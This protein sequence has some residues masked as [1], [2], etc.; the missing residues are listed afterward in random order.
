MTSNPQLQKL[1]G[2]KL[3]SKILNILQD[4]DWY[5]S[6]LELITIQKASI[7]SALF[8]CVYNPNSLI[9]W[10]AV[11]TFGILV[12]ILSINEIEKIRILVRRCIWMLT[13]ESGGIPWGVPE[14]IGEIC[15][16]SEQMAQEFNN[17]LLSYVFESNGPENYL[18]HT[19][20]RK[21]VYWGILRLAQSFPEKVR[22]FE[23]VIEQRIK[24]E[25]EPVI[26][27]Y[28][29]MIIDQANL[30]ELN[31]YCNQFIKDKRKIEIFINNH[32]INTNLSSIA[33][34]IIIK[35]ST[36]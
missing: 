24:C 6:L 33:N 34:E 26:V 36:F 23:Y 29:M 31:D 35:K 2:R 9:K 16:N 18:E 13:E 4:D 28:L 8:S 7:T 14:V 22:E 32:F 11:A 10:R 12:K 3:K 5:S 15:A 20:L 27:G 19:P 21:G 17:M 25:N 30:S 1:K